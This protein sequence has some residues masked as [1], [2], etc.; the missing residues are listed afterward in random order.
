MFE[1][2]S[3]YDMIVWKL[4]EDMPYVNIYPIGD[5]HFGSPE[6]NYKKWKSWKQQILADPF[7][8]VVLLGDMIDNGLKNS[9][10][11]VYKATMSPIEQKRMLAEE[12][13]DIK[14]LI[15]AGVQGNHEH[16]STRETGDCPMYDV[17]AKLDLEHLYRENMAFIKVNVGQRTADRQFSYGLVASHGGSKPKVKKFVPYVDG[18]DVFMSGHIHQASSEFP[19]KI[20]MDMK[21]E[22][23]RL[24]P[25]TPVVVPSFSD[26]GGYAMNRLY[27]PTSNHLMPIITLD[28]TDRKEVNIHWV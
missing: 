13:M 7:S 12:L 19:A 15:L 24:T 8:R 4:P 23:V 18:M 14:H 1:M 25:V 9:K 22:V 20:V 6:F 17:M 5:T 26:Y 16:R 21:N 2:K 27:E 10:T 3:D 11:D 28:G